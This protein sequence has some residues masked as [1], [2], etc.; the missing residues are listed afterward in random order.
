[1]RS[2][3]AQ[4]AQQP[5]VSHICMHVRGTAHTRANQGRYRNLWEK[6]YRDVQAIIFVVD[7]TDRIRMCVAQVRATRCHSRCRLCARHRRSTEPCITPHNTHPPP[8][9]AVP[10][11]R[12]SSRTS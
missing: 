10:P 4:C 5:H 7:S 9:A 2:D 6:Y 11:P 1:M 12:T 8:H 3:G